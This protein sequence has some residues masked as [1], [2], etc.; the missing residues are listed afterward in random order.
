LKKTHFTLN[1]IIG[2][3]NFGSFGTNGNWIDLFDVIDEDKVSEILGFISFYINLMFIRRYI[4][5][6]YWYLFKKNI[7]YDKEND[8][9]PYFVCESEE[10]WKSY[11]LGVK[12]D[13]SLI[14]PF[15]LY[16]EGPTEQTILEEYTNH[17][18][19]R[20]SIT[21]MQ[22][23][24]NSIYYERLC[25]DSNIMKYFF[26]FDVHNIDEFD[27][28]RNLY[29][30]N[31][32]FFFPDFIT[33]NFSIDEIYNSFQEWINEIN[34]DISGESLIDIKNKITEE[35]NLSDAMNNEFKNLNRITTHN[36]KG[37]EKIIINELNKKYSPEIVRLF[38]EKFKLTLNNHIENL[39]EFKDFVKKNLSQKL[40]FYVANS[41]P[42]NGARIKK[43]TFEYKLKP[44]LNRITEVI[45]YQLGSEELNNI[46]RNDE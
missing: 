18:F 3:G 43:F 19:L 34:L 31:C 4:E 21:S 23:I 11:L 6:S 5:R 45:N 27:K 29:G 10:E 20:F 46:T 37:F 7:L 2:S 14:N 39:K 32:T 33:E 35:K 12:V 13:F 30:E 42:K 17:L 24:S 41:Y 22:G 16:V 26:V 36:S 40:R 8:F 38:P 1:H 15:I 25:R 44:F 9:K 28:M